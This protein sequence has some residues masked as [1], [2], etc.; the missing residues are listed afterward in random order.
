MSTPEPSAAA[1]PSATL[2]VL[3]MT[4][5]ATT[6]AQASTEPTERSKL[7]EAR[8]KSMVDETIPTV[9]TA[10]SKPW[11]FTT[12]RKSL[13]KMAEA[14]NSRASTNNMPARS[15]QDE[16]CCA[17]RLRCMRLFSKFAGGKASQKW[18]AAN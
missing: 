16:S 15:H 17:E 7:P 13:T 14:A 4:T 10:S 1:T 11:R 2:P 5:A 12:E 18:R 8:Q 3:F 6:P 9:E